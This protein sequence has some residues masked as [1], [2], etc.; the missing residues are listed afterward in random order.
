MSSA[1][2]APSEPGK[3]A[4][5]LLLQSCP[6][7]A[8]VIKYL[9]QMYDLSAIEFRGASAGALIACLAACQVRCLWS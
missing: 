2:S 7:T 1:G 4:I 6:G 9:I 8:G 3:A 5:P